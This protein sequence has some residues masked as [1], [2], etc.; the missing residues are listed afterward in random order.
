MISRRTVLVGVGSIPAMG[1]V[2]AA[3]AAEPPA[4]HPWQRARDLASELAEVLN[5]GDM[6]FGGPGGGWYAQV[7]PSAVRDYPV[8]FCDIR[9]A[10]WPKNNITLPL[11]RLIE[12]HKQAREAFGRTCDKTDRIALGKEPSKVAWRRWRKAGRAEEAALIAVCGFVAYGR[13]D[14]M[15]KARYLAPY[16]QAG[17]LYEAHILTLINSAVRA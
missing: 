6:A 2:D 7:Y 9:A 17:E 13:A 3:A 5:E 11:T 1:A 10:E 16:A 8:G 15:A 14:A 12:A 4:D